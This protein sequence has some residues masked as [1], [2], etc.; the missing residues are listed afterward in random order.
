MALRP[1]SI[2]HLHSQRGDATLRLRLLRH[3]KRASF[4]QNNNLLLRVT[5]IYHTNI[6]H[7][8]GLHRTS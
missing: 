3:R 7:F 8:I 6:A 1:S 5:T 4:P 2:H